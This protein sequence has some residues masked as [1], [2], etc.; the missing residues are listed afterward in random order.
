MTAQDR[1]AAVARYRGAR[2]ELDRIARRDRAETDEWA[3]A[4]DE[5]WEAAKAVPWWRRW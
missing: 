5:M 4:N 1:R 2:D 3:D